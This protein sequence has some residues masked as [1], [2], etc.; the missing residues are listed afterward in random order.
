MNFPVTIVPA[1]KENA[2]VIAQLIMT[3]MSEECCAYFYGEQHT[4][5]DFHRLLTEL[6]EMENTQYSFKNALVAISDNTIIGTAVSYD[7]ALL[8]TLR[9][10]FIDGVL[11]HFG[12]DFSSMDDETAA[13]ELY[14]DSFAVL[15]E[16]RKRGIGSRLLQATIEKSVLLRL[17]CV[18]LLVDTDNPNAEKLYLANGFHFVN[19]TS[20]G[21]HSMKHLQTKNKTSFV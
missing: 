21:G 7:G 1:R 2:S 8:H 13:G 11:Q 17:P 20:W 15:P 5:A 3:A 6:V 14:L 10:A 18:G 16:Y 19:F 4:A 12:R 9:K